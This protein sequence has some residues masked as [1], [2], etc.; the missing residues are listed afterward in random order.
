MEQNA[1][2]VAEMAPELRYIR[3][4]MTDGQVDDFTDNAPREVIEKALFAVKRFSTISG[5]ER[6]RTLSDDDQSGLVDMIGE[7][8][9]DRLA[10]LVPG[11]D[12]WNA[13]SS[14]SVPEY[15]RQPP[16]TEEER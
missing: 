13:L 3:P 9:V 4:H 7:A 1:L 16:I 8:T 5:T 6:E 14:E 15:R 2:A 12:L 10:R 11:V